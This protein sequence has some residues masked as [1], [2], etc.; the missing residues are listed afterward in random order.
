MRTG[1][2]AINTVVS[3][4]RD[5]STHMRA[6]RELLDQKQYLETIL[7]TTND[8]FWVV[9]PEGVITLVN[10]SYCRMS[11][12]TRNELTGMRVNGIDAVEE[13]RETAE[14]M[15]RILETGSETFETQHRRKDG[16]IFDVEVSVSRLDRGEEYSLVCFCRDIS[17][18]KRAEAAVEQQL[19]EKNILLKEVHHRVKNNIAT[20]EAFL[21]LQAHSTDSAEAAAALRDA[22]SR[23]QNM[24]VLYETLLLEGT[25][26]SVSIRDYI[27]NVLES[28][29]PVVQDEVGVVIETS[30]EDF[31]LSTRTAVPVGIVINELLTNVFKYAFAPGATGRRGDQARVSITLRRAGSR[32]TLTIQDNG[33]GIP[34]RTEADKSPGFGLEIVRM[35]AEQLDGTCRMETGRGTTSVLEFPVR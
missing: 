23:V 26:D 14:R 1:D 28:L 13:P 35:L 16:T 17:E 6:E 9:S 22:V 11:G 29:L 12:Y 18:R 2:G 4:T 8:G 19:R 5:V 34:E 33:S 31:S 27:E 10:E 15:E 24:R 21:S 25:Y 3:V 7:E 20:I 32:A 30:I